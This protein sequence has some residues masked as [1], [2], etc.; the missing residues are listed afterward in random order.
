MKEDELNRKIIEYETTFKNQA[1]V[2]NT[3]NK[4]QQI[5]VKEVDILKK[6]IPPVE[7]KKEEE[8]DGK[9]E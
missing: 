2:I 7:I 9:T 6:A 4:N 3:L 5:L 8:K 1:E